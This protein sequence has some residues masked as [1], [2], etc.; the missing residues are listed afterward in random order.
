[1]PDPRTPVLHQFLI[2][3]ARSTLTSLARAKIRI[4]KKNVDVAIVPKPNPPFSIGFVSKSPNVAPKGLVKTNA[5]PKSN[6]PEIL[7]F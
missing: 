4:P 2:P 1:M 3:F 5:I 6:I 7:E